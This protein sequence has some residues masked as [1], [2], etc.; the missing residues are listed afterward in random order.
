[1][2]N[3]EHATL[4]KY[5]GENVWK[6]SLYMTLSMKKANRLPFIT[7]SRSITATILAKTLC[8]LLTKKTQNLQLDAFCMQH[9]SCNA[10]IRNVN[11]KLLCCC[12]R[13]FVCLSLHEHHTPKSFSSPIVFFFLIAGS[14]SVVGH[15]RVGCPHLRYQSCTCFIRLI[16][17]CS[18]STPYNS[19]SAVG[20]Q[21]GT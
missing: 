12:F 8:R 1:M 13:F 21:P 10:R 7:H 19:A 14:I 2:E 4:Y 9:Q 16:F 5:L 11:S 3:V 17:F 15:S 20:G 6:L 18:C